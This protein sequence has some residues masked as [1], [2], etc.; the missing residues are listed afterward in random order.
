MHKHEVEV[1]G[2][3]TVEVNHEVDFGDYTFGN[4]IQRVDGPPVEAYV[5]VNDINPHQPFTDVATLRRFAAD[6]MNAADWLESLQRSASLP[7]S[8]SSS[9]WAQPRA[10]SLRA[11]FRPYRHSPPKGD[12]GTSPP[13]GPWR[14]VQAPC[15]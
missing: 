4:V 11:S 9:S 10:T 1:A 3:G 15:P 2:D 7:C 8:P 5:T 12:P 14:C 13:L 6:L